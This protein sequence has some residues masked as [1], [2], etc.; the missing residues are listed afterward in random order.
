MYKEDVV[1]E[2]IINY[3]NWKQLMKKFICSSFFVFSM[4]AL[5]AQS[6]WQETN[7]TKEYIWSFATAPNGY[8]YAAGNS[9]GVYRSID[10]GLTWTPSSA[11]FTELILKYVTAV[12]VNKNNIVFA[13]TFGGTVYKSIDYGLTWTLVNP[14]YNL[15][16]INC[17][18]TLSNGDL[19]AGSDVIGVNYSSDNGV[20]W[21]QKNYGISNPKV[22]SLAQFTN[23]DLYAGTD[24][25]G[26]YKSTN[27]AVTWTS[28]GFKTVSTK[29]TSIVKDDL[30]TLFVTVWGQQSLGNGGLF[31]SA[32]EGVQWAKAPV[33][34]SVQAFSSAITNSKGDIFISVFSDGVYRS[35]DHGKNWNE[36]KSGFGYAGIQALGIAQNGILLAGTYGAGIYKTISPTT[37]IVQSKGV[38][39]NYALYQ[40]YPN[41]FNPETTI[42]YKLQAAGKVSLKV[43]DLLGREVTTLVDEF[44]QPGNYKVIFN[45]KTPYQNR[46]DR[47]L[48]GIASLHSGVYFYRIEVGRFSKG[49]KMLLLK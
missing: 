49:M 36:Y 21:I 3:R 39:A 7:I 15:G 46:R 4:V 30:G 33:A 45:A 20:T 27:L 44:K 41:P 32:N 22:K 34:T 12:T 29:I 17:I 2:I 8:I 28:I 13:G 6:V 18:I 23:G 47:V 1:N 40:N 10:N 38:T 24:S 43:F 5:N 37:D 31:S 48:T 9:S 14:S 42:S 16:A 35:T 26:L 19:L 11:G 25:D